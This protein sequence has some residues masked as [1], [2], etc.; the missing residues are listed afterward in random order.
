MLREG[1]NGWFAGPHSAESCSVLTP[2]PDKAT[3]CPVSIIDVHIIPRKQAGQWVL[4]A[5]LSIWKMASG[6]QPEAIF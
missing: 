3:S 6:R 5:H 2:P 1:D 4:C